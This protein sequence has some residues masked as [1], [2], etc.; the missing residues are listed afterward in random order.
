MTLYAMYDAV[1][2]CDCA[3]KAPL[4][5][6]A[7]RLWGIVFCLIVSGGVLPVVYA[8]SRA[9]STVSAL[10]KAELVIQAD[11]PCLV[12]VDGVEVARL[13]AGGVRRV[14]LTTGEKRIEAIGEHP[15]DR[16]EKSMFVEPGIKRVVAIGMKRVIRERE[17]RE[18][19]ELERRRD[20]EA[21][22]MLMTA[23][24]ASLL[25]PAS[26]VLIPPGVFL[27]VDEH[28][29]VRQEVAI[30]RNIAMGRYEVT[31]AQWESVMGDN[32]SDR[33]GPFHPVESVSWHRVQSFLDSLNALDASPV[34]YRLPTEAEWEYACRA[35]EV[36][37]FD[38]EPA[39]WY[40]ENAGETTHPVGRKTPNAWGLFD[41]RGNVWEWVEDWYTLYDLTED[42]DPVVTEKGRARVIRG[43]SWWSPVEYTTC[44]Y[45][46][47]LSPDY[48]ATILG[49]RI[50]REEPPLPPD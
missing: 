45:R 14:L 6:L 49:F 31:Q 5:G 43:G 19:T 34:M 24:R 22:A 4:R 44:T 16:W 29:G 25:D 36:E 2:Y 38:P 21:H 42:M 39:A 47:N 17:E 10:E 46:G 37:A 26:Y 18:K 41:M 33:R 11:A 30:T 20:A 9:A 15:G 32:P 27:R 23:A 28:R 7:E 35:N 48:K 8:Q 13:S 1:A 40:I 12:M 50:V 3:R